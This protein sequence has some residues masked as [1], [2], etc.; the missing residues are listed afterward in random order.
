MHKADKNCIFK[1]KNNYAKSIHFVDVQLSSHL[2]VTVIYLLCGVIWFF[3]RSQILLELFIQYVSLVSVLFFFFLTR[4]TCT[5]LVTMW[6]I[7]NQCAVLWGIKLLIGVLW[8][9]SMRRHEKPQAAGR[10]DYSHIVGVIVCVCV[11]VCV[12]G[13]GI[14]SLAP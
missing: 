14:G 13:G 12:C 4:H 8:P 9:R 2:W 7:N 1:V 3:V 10:D 6:L 5:S 11:C